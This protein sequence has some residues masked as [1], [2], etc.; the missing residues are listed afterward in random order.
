MNKLKETIQKSGMK[1]FIIARLAGV[2][3]GRMTRIITG[4]CMPTDVEMRALAETLKTTI[5][6]LFGEG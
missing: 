4:R 3:E 6:E 1:Q 2:S 5:R